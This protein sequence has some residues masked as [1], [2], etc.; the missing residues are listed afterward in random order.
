MKPPIKSTTK[1]NENQLKYFSIKGLIFSPFQPNRPATRKNLADRLTAEAIRN[2]IKLM[3]AM[4]A[5][6]VQAFYMVMT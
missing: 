5:E 3:L 1:A 2:P 4:P 6:I